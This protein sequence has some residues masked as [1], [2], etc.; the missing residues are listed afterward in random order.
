M[1]LDSKKIV[2]FEALVRWQHPVRGL[3]APADFIPVAEETGLI[4]QLGEWVLRESCRQAAHWPPEIR[5]AVNLSAIQFK[6]GRLVETVGDILRE[7]NLTADRLELEITESALLQETDGNLVA[8]RA[9]RHLGVSISLDDFGTGYSSLGYLRKFPFDKIKIDRSFVGDLSREGESAA[10][11]RAV[12][13]LGKALGITTV[14]EGVETR[15]QLRRLRAEGCAEVQGYLISKP[16]P[17]AEVPLMLRAF[18]EDARRMM[19]WV[20]TG[21]DPAGVA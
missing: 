11:V 18:G 12:I 15:T 19:P 21:L 8:L 3:I 16:G 1:N 10:I 14:A 20:A 13:G 17:A 2:A 5:L 9:L 7:S 6:N 4:V